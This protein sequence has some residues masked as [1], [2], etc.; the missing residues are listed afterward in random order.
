MP[1]ALPDS[2]LGSI[3]PDRPLLPWPQLLEVF[4][5]FDTDRSGA[6]DAEELKIALRVVLGSDLSLDDCV[7]LVSAADRDGNGAVDFQEFCFVCRGEIT[8]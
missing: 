5:K 6:L 4:D 3:S 7:Q 8:T 1:T 2:L